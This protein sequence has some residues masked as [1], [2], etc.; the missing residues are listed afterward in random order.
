MH[1]AIRLQDAGLQPFAY[2]PQEGFV[3]YP[4]RQQL[5]QFFVIDS[6]EKASDVRLYQVVVTPASQHGAQRPDSL[7]S[8]YPGAISLTAIEKIGLVDC[9]QY[10]GDSYLQQFVGC[11]RYTQGSQFPIELG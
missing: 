6:V 10:L 2:E 1:R 11:C 4:Q 8:P 5:D 7:Q 9:F 3:V